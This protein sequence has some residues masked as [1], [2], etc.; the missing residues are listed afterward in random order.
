MLGDGTNQV[1]EMNLPGHSRSTVSV[2]E[3]LGELD[4]SSHDFS[5]RVETTDGTKI[6]CE[7][8]IYFN[9]QGYTRLNWPGGH[10]VVGALEPS[11]TWYFAEGTV[12]P[13][14]DS[15]ICIQ[16]PNDRTAN[17]LISYMPEHGEVVCKSACVPANSRE[18]VVPREQVKYESDPN[19]DYS[20]KV[21][22]SNGLDVI[23]ERP[24]YFDYLGSKARSWKGGHNTLGVT[25]PSKSWFFAEGYTGI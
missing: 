19:Q 15:Y 18:T 7:R 14:F 11:P 10:N 4:D 24:I 21:E 13:S 3:V 12:R 9:Y 17:L 20:I 5:A 1:Q 22:C 8:P 16:N 25:R 6:I 23:C 2:K